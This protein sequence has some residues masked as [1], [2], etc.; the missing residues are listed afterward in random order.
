[1]PA[2]QPGDS[3]E[4]LYVDIA[5]RADQLVQDAEE[6][7]QAVVKNLDQIE[8]KTKETQ[9][10]FSQLGDFIKQSFTV[11]TGIGL[12]NIG[13]QISQSIVG[14][15]RAM[16]QTNAQMQTYEQS[17]TV[18]TGSAEEAGEI[19]EWVKEQAKETPFDVPGL[20]EASQM[21]MTWG[22]DLKEW[23]TVVGDTA[24]AMNK[25]LSQVVGAIGSLA[26]GQTGEA[27]MRFRNLGLN[28]REYT[29]LEFDAQGALV[30]PLEKALPIV[31]QIME[32]RFGGMMAAQSKTWAG[33]MSNM[34]DT[35][36]QFIQIVGEPIFE[37]LN[38][39]LLDLQ[40]WVNENQEEI[41]TFASN[42]G[43]SLSDA[44]NTAKD[45][46]GIFGKL[47]DF[48]AD[49][50]KEEIEIGSIEID[51]SE[52][53][54]ER[55]IQQIKN[56]AGDAASALGIFTGTF[57][58]LKE[59]FR[60]EAPEGMNKI[61]HAL[62][63]IK[64]NM[65]GVKEEVVGTDPVIKDVTTSVLELTEAQR[66][67][68]QAVRDWHPGMENLSDQAVVQQVAIADAS[69]A[70]E[71]YMVILASTGMVS[72]EALE[73]YREQYA[74]V[75]A[76]TDVYRE[77]K[78]QY[79]EVTEAQNALTEA[80]AAQTAEMQAAREA[81]TEVAE[82]MGDRL[83][84][85]IDQYEETVAGL[86]EST[87]EAIA[88]IEAA[89][90]QSVQDAT[91][92]T[93]D[94]IARLR[95]DFSRE[96]IRRRRQF[97]QEWARLIREQNQENLDAEW[98]YQYRK[99]QLLLE[100]DEI[101]LA[102]LEARYAHEKD[103][104]GRE[105][106]DARGDLQQ[107]FDEENQERQDQFER[108]IEA[109][110]ERLEIEVENIREKAAEEVQ[111]KKDALEER[112]SHEDAK[113]EERLQKLGENLQTEI[114]DNELATT[115]ILQAWEQMY[116]AQVAAALAAGM[117]IRADLDAITLRA[118]R[119]SSALQTALRSPT[120]RGP[121]TQQHVEGGV[122]YQEGGYTPDAKTSIT[123]DP[124]EWVATAATTRALENA[125]GGPLTQ[126]G[127]Q[128][129]ITSRRAL[130]VNINAAGLPADMI[131]KLYDDLLDAMNEETGA[132]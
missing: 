105:Q 127:V 88:G 29:Q 97:N 62:L 128:A 109:L 86:R 33:V 27:V 2:Q 48:V 71:A 84:D 98:E 63:R 15:G 25:P 34:G 125:L 119:A 82:E 115:I 47:L 90:E 64:E 69:R 9:S 61:D 42:L 87:A 14:F 13:A 22:L 4:T 50:N 106:G 110:Q 18:L 116:G 40:K 121:G 81:V 16:I 93:Q 122:E 130:D 17:F 117:Q 103:V 85:A 114:G 79:E 78:T 49:V 104:R 21:L 73:A 19:I 57:Q 74:G 67:A 3:I 70:T 6:A 80:Y 52:G 83:Q 46:L 60:G 12:A 20:I 65:Q 36:Q 111:A 94:E 72:D 75:R 92:R 45:L 107:G 28:L 99:E 123:T 38:A 129:L 131:E 56:V 23:F 112:L 30:T 118:I 10:A 96:Q 77:A 66:I 101:V 51:I 132:Y 91:A 11:A 113:M 76:L 59:S 68:T 41:E 100:G 44:L 1:V 8:D 126:G 95:E 26:S 5:A 31:R 37:T 124:G 32:E 102:E 54:F 55:D 7:I 89:A 58:A 24:A 53:S 43:T 120:R 39:A 35:W 108:Q